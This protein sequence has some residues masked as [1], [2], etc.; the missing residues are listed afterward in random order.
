MI[1]YFFK[2]LSKPDISKK[3]KFL[4]KLPS[5]VAFFRPSVPV[6]GDGTNAKRAEFYVAEVWDSPGSGKATASARFGGS[7]SINKRRKPR[8]ISQRI[9]D[10]I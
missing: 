2:K 5:V 10:R 7:E 1:C 8:I 6:S 4:R 9:P 3:S